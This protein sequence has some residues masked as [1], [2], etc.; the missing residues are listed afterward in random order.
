[1]KINLY[2]LNLCLSAKERIIEEPRIKK[3]AKISLA[4]RNPYAEEEIRQPPPPPFCST[5]F[6]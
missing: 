2:F 5:I 3:T 6:S 4:I 1:M